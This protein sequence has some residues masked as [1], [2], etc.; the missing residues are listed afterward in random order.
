ME[1]KKTIWVD[2]L[3]RKQARARNWKKFRIAGI[4]FPDV[5]DLSTNEE[6]LIFRMKKLQKELLENWDRET[7]KVGLKP[8]KKK[9]GKNKILG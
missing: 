2:T 1:K 7:K 5:R 3:K 8:L 6:I 4:S 9:D